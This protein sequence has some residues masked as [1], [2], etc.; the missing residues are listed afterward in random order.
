MYE[1]FEYDNAGLAIERHEAFLSSGEIVY[2]KVFVDSLAKTVV[3]EIQPDVKFTVSFREDGTRL[4]RVRGFEHSNNELYEFFNQDGITR[5][6]VVFRFDKIGVVYL[7]PDGS[8]KEA[9]RYENGKFQVVVYKPGTFPAQSDFTNVPKAGVKY[10]Q[11]WSEVNGDEP[12]LT[13]LDEY[14]SSG[15]VYRRLYFDDSELSK[16]EYLDSDG[17]VAHKVILK[18]MEEDDSTITLVIPGLNL[19]APQVNYNRDSTLLVDR[20]DPSNDVGSPVEE[21]YPY[22]GYY[23]DYEEYYNHGPDGYPV[24]ETLDFP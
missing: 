24:Q 1:Q 4:Y 6:S 19:P 11:Y 16:A 13:Q 14:R 5:D 21:Y 23:D 15:S 3:E 2:R 18:P 7:N 10:K 20:P 9:R 17:D 22:E 8:L 12:L